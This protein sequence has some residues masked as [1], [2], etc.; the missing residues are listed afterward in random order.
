[1]AMVERLSAVI[2]HDR[3][4]RV[5]PQIIWTVDDEYAGAFGEQCGVSP[6]GQPRV[7]NDEFQNT[8]SA[9]PDRGARCHRKM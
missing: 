2:C 7:I 3:R 6:P 8:L 5:T 9:V 4:W 1:M